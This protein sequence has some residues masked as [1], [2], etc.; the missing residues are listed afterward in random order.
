[1][2]YSLDKLHMPH[3][4]EALVDSILQGCLASQQQ[5][6][7]NLYVI[8]TYLLTVPLGTFLDTMRK[9][10]VALILIDLEFNEV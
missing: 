7:H 2:K 6:S 5:N 3:V 9:G 8:L 10:G 1:M 4:G